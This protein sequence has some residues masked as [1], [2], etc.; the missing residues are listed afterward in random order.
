MSGLVA[1]NF[2]L[3]SVVIPCRNE[4]AGIV[5]L[6]RSVKAQTP[7]GSDLEILIVDDGST[8][9]TSQLAEAEGARVLSIA[10]KAGG[11]NPAVARNLGARASRG[12]P[13]IFLDS[14]CL[15]HDGWLD[16][17]L[18]EHAAGIEVV[19][20]SLDLPS[21]LGFSARCD[22]YCGWYHVH[23]GRASA[24]VQ[25]HPPCN[26]SARREVFLA[27]SGYTERQ[28]IAYAHEELVWQA[29]VLAN[30]GRIFFDPR[31]VVDH[32]NRPGFSNLLR[33]NYRWGYSALES[34]ATTGTARFAFLY[35]HPALLVL[36][37]MPLSFASTAYI[38]GCWLKGGRIEPLL[39]APAI[40]AAR[41]AYAAGMAE[42]GLRWIMKPDQRTL[43]HRPRWE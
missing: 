20:G 42:G 3:V 18:K 41:L 13:I 10:A 16:A 37:S 22:Y 28:P 27:G 29:E 24:W 14:D 30:G 32:Y 19:G 35:R 40:F 43:E 15:P 6:I 25:H 36:A 2:P 1:P 33:R 7:P 11:G 31:A 8:D 38:I 21:G 39:M 26:I 17:L 12:D 4:A 5:T 23:P 9:N 34:K